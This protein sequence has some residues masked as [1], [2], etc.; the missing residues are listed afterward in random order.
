MLTSEKRP[1]RQPPN[2]R[3][4]R[5]PLVGLSRCRDL[6]RRVLGANWPRFPSRTPSQVRLRAVMRIFDRCLA[7]SPKQQQSI[8]PEYKTICMQLSRYGLEEP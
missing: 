7:L 5:G 1:V 3:V 6:I 4:R 2:Q 8:Q